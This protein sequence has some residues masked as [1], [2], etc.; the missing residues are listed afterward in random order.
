MEEEVK[1]RFSELAKRANKVNIRVYEIETNLAEKQREL[2]NIIERMRSGGGGLG[3]AWLNL[4]VAEVSQA[5]VRLSE[6]ATERG[7]LKDEEL[8]IRDALTLLTEAMSSWNLVDTV[9]AELN[10]ARANIPKI[11]LEK[12]KESAGAALYD[13]EKLKEEES[14]LIQEEAKAKE[15]EPKPVTENNALNIARHAAGE[16]QQEAILR[17]NRNTYLRIAREIQE[18]ERSSKFRSTPGNTR[19][20]SKQQFLRLQRNSIKTEPRP[21]KVKVRDS[22]QLQELRKQ[23]RDSARWHHVLQDKVNK[24]DLVSK[25]EAKLEELIAAAKHNSEKAFAIDDELRRLSGGKRKVSLKK[26]VHLTR[27]KSR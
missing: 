7:K 25:L 3:Q 26:R 10:V 21:L 27:R 18:L 11:S 23:I 17:G 15:S 5:E 2:N 12:A 4:R 22:I 20:L 16:A 9:T 8:K 24:F 1:R 19:G 6:T 13:L 14:Q